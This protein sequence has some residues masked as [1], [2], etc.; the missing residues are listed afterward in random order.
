NDG[1][2][3]IPGNTGTGLFAV[4]TSNAGVS[5]TITMT[6]DTGGATVPVA[7]SIC[8]TDPHTSACLAPPSSSVTRVIGPTDRPPLGGFGGGSGPVAFDPAAN[9]IF[10]RFLEGNVTRGSTSVAVR[11]Q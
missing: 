3:N 10:V 9:R 4:A 5:G 1:I 8:E 2:V 11:T 7:I 6:A